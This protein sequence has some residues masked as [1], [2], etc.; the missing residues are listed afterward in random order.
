M[1]Q[2]LKEKLDKALNSGKVALEDVQTI[3]KN[4]TK[5][6]VE[7]SKAQGDDLKTTT[8]DFFKEVINSLSKVGKGGVE[9]IKAAGE[10]FKEGVKESTDGDKNLIKETGEALGEGL[11][12]LAEV[13]IYVTHET[14]KNLSSVIENLFKTED[15]K[16]DDKNDQDYNSQE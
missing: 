12:S 15:D 13:G 16:K 8:G 9:F 5:E 2:N 1:D 4:I 10:G 14:V 3:V 7:K 6:V 11:K